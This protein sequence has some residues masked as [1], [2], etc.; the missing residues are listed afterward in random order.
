VD[1]S[2]GAGDLVVDVRDGTLES[3]FTFRLE[4]ALERAERNA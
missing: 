2:L 1:S 3:H 4:S